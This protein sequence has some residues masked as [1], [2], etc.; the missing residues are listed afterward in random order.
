MIFWVVKVLLS[1]KN[2][3]TLSIIIVL[4]TIETVIVLFSLARISNS[5][6]SDSYIYKEQSRKEAMNKNIFKEPLKA[7]KKAG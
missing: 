7:K 2:Q 5:K 4:P 6:E 1:I 3:F